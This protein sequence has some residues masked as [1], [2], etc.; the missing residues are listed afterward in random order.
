MASPLESALLVQVTADRERTAG[1]PFRGPGT[2]ARLIPFVAIAVLAE[3]SLAL[4]PGP[5]S[6]SAVIASVVLLLATAAAFLV[7]WSQLPIWM[8]V[9]VPIVYTGSVLALVLAAGSTSGVGIVIL[10]PLVW[11]ALFHRAWESACIVAVIVAV[12]VIIS[13][14]PAAAPDAVI[15]RRVIL[16]AALGT[17]ISVAVHGLRDHIRR[18]QEETAQL[19]ARL[20]E[21][22]VL[23]DRDRIAADLQDKVIQRVFAVGLTLQ[24][25]ATL[26][27][28]P[29]VRRRVAASV[30]DLDHV[31]RL[32]RD[33]IFGLEQHLKAPGLR[34]ELLALCSQMGLAPE[35]SFS[36]PVDGALQP[37]T[38]TQLLDLLRDA[39]RWISQHSG[40]CRIG[41]HASENAY[42]T[43]IEASGRAGSSDEREPAVELTAIRDA[44]TKVGIEIDIELTP[45]G[46]RFKWHVPIAP[47]E[48]QPTHAP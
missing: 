20:R 16:W 38:R 32:L 1:Y 46:T 40:R 45:D 48:Q 14:T 39:L 23:Q 21:L 11:T 24:G 19:E 30:D 10:I 44:A 34:Q 13:L 41:V 7:P 43:V 22:T 31:L 3:V 8:P 26:T 17:V 47:R 4:P 2:L 5:R 27:A 42:V 36:G 35:V 9:L 15:A 25:A 12:E 33:S 28:E 29:E 6:A 18:S 37:G